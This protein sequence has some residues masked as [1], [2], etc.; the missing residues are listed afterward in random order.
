M[1]L[2]ILLMGKVA[3][4]HF[5]VSSINW[6]WY[7]KMLLFYQIVLNELLI[8]VNTRWA[9]CNEAHASKCT[10]LKKLTGKRVK[11]DASLKLMHQFFP[12][13]E[14]HVQWPSTW[15]LNYKNEVTRK[16]KWLNHF[17]LLNAYV[18]VHVKCRLSSR[19]ICK[20]LTA[21]QPHRP[22]AAAACAAG[23]VVIL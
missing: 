14:Q 20:F 21:P 16:L 5:G 17:T 11:M 15:P 8:H 2:I 9:C 23:L 7:C 22:I 18:H 1:A 3:I 6:A 19:S 12:N 4:L 10:F 13:F